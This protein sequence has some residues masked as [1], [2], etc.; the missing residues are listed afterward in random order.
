MDDVHALDMFVAGVAFGGVVLCA[1][2]GGTDFDLFAIR[3]VAVALQDVTGVVQY[4]LQAVL[5]VADQ[6]AGVVG[7]AAFG[8]GDQ[9]DTPD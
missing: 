4:G 3:G 1:Q 9:G 5:V 6:V 8:L 2:Y 7:V